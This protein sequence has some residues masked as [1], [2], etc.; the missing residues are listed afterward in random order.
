M[1][2]REFRPDGG[3]YLVTRDTFR[4]PRDFDI[5]WSRLSASDQA[6]VLTEINRRLQS[7]ID[8]PTRWGALTNTSIEGGR[9][10]PLTGVRG[11]WTGTP[12]APLYDACS[13]N[14]EL[15]G[16]LFGVVFKWVVIDRPERWIGYRSDPTFPTK[17]QTLEG[18]S[19]FLAEEDCPSP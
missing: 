18:K 11:D 8:R 1:A 13:E 12:L 10:N 15:A 17:D 6:G 5:L 4:Y 16:Q 19:Y 2:L 7:Q 14:E 9:V 3:T